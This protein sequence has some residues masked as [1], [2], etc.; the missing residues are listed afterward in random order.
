MCFPLDDWEK[1]NETPLLEKEDFNSYLNIEHNSDADLTH[2]KR[3]SR[4][5]KI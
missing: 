3:V 5:F 1:F 4:D 2:E